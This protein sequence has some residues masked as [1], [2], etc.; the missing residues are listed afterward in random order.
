MTGAFRVDLARLL[1]GVGPSP[2]ERLAF[3]LLDSEM[4]CVAC[5]RL[6]QFADRLRRR[7]ALAIP[8]VIGHRIWNRWCT[9]VHHCHISRHARIGPGFVIMHRNGINIG[10]IVA[11]RDFTVYQN[12]TVGMRIAHN[13]QGVPTFGRSV[14]I[15]PGSTISG[16]VSIGDRVTISAGTVLARD[17][18]EGSLV[19]GNPGRVISRDYD[20][21]A[22]VNAV[23]PRN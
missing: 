7:T 5:Y 10:P 18:P 6:G 13:G 19:A 16:N 21:T 8:L 22:I 11:G 1:D 20:N 17:V 9:H 2:K 3:W 23:E 12:V 4:H 15:G 14:W